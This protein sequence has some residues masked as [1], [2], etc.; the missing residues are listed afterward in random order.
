MPRVNQIARDFRERFAEHE[1]R[2]RTFGPFELVF[3]GKSDTN[4]DCMD[5]VIVPL[6]GVL[7]V[8][9][10]LGF[11]SYWWPSNQNLSL[12]FLAGCS[13]RYF[14]Q[15][16]QSSENGQCPSDWNGAE[17]KA[18]L[19]DFWNGLEGEERKAVPTLKEALCALECS[20][21][22]EWAAWVIAEM[23]ALDLDCDI[24]T[25]ITE[26]GSAPNPYTVAHWVGL[27]MAHEA[28]EGRDEQD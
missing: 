19:R 28:L 6:A 18:A 20:S 2:R 21:R 1:A 9:G 27:K 16:C 23:S 25:F 13:F 4:I 17:G 15:K 10:D 22:E 3:W 14:R 7:H 12:A 26:I 5:F 24:L 8:M 11:A